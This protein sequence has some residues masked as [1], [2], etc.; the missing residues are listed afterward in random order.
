LIRLGSFVRITRSADHR[1]PI[2]VIR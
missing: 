2:G 1:D